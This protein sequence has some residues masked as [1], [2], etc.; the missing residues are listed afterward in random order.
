M[1]TPAIRCSLKRG[2]SHLDQDCICC[3]PKWFLKQAEKGHRRRF[4]QPLDRRSCGTSDHLN[5]S[6][7][8]LLLRIVS[9]L[10]VVRMKR[11]IRFSLLPTV[12][13]AKQF[14]P[15]T[16]TICSANLHRHRIPEC[17]HCRQ[18]Q[19]TFEELCWQPY[20]MDRQGDT[21]TCTPT[22]VA[23]Y[24]LSPEAILPIHETWSI[25][26]RLGSFVGFSSTIAK[27]PFRGPPPCSS[28]A[29]GRANSCWS[30]QNPGKH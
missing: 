3:W 18:H 30:A 2:P 23:V 4:S 1:H 29:N 5:K 19:R 13:S 8:V 16:R 9:S 24:V 17:R 11:F 10:I 21:L 15:K 25:R 26:I 27:S 7:L 14:P 20:H 28:L 12:N 6:K 22:H